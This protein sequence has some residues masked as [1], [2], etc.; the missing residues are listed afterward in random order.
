MKSIQAAGC[1]VL[2]LVGHL[3]RHEQ[4]YNHCRG[5]ACSYVMAQWNA[6]LKVQNYEPDRLENN[7]IEN[8]IRVSTLDKKNFLLNGAP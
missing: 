8:A 5:K 6:L 7:L 3:Y 1:V 4:H 2:S